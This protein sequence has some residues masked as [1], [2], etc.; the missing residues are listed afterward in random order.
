MELDTF[1][2]YK[3][4]KTIPTYGRK[5]ETLYIIEEG[6]TSIC[7]WFKAI[8]PAWIPSTSHQKHDKLVALQYFLQS[9]VSQQYYL[10]TI[11][12]NPAPD[13]LDEWSIDWKMKEVLS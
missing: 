11:Q 8:P 10:L 6:N 2:T 3:H 5:V 1:H 7:V 9:Q 12:P 4:Y 13:H